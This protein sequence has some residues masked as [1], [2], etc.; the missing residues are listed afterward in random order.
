MI[1]LNGLWIAQFFACWSEFITSRTVASW[2]LSRNSS[3]GMIWAMCDGLTYSFGTNACHALIH[4]SLDLIRKLSKKILDSTQNESSLLSMIIH[5]VF[6]GILTFLTQL[7]HFSL[8]ASA[9]YGTNFLA[10]TTR[11][12]RCLFSDVYLGLFVGA[13]GVFV[14][15]LLAGL[16]WFVSWILVPLDGSQHKRAESL[17]L[18]A[19]FFHYFRIIG[20][21]AKT[22]LFL[23][24]DALIP[25]QLHHE[26]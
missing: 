7:N 6:L 11:A 18:Y 5:K 17:L 9:L 2:Y 10:S 19:I 16:V 21:A 13:Q 24:V 12:L 3:I 20:T 8:V 4:L 22:I 25:K 14:E 23:Q 1:F 26:E 15:A